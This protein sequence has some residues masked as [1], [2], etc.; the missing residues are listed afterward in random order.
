MWTLL[1]INLR[2]HVRCVCVC[3]CARYLWVP[4][5]ILLA[6][7]NEFSRSQT[8]FRFT[9]QSIRVSHSCYFRRVVCSLKSQLSCCVFFNFSYLNKIFPHFWHS[10]HFYHMT[11]WWRR[12]CWAETETELIGRIP[13]TAQW[14]VFVYTVRVIRWCFFMQFKSQL[15]HFSCRAWCTVNNGVYGFMRSMSSDQ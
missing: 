14:Y 3:V 1:K 13:L 10:P 4:N 2:K 11:A 5:N 6:I 15:T 12:R 7:P 9:P 8:C